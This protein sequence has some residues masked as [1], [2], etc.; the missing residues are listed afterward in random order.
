MIEIRYGDY[1]EV[2]DMAG[3]SVSEA[4]KQ[5]KAEFGIPDKTGAKL[6]GNKVKGGLES[7]IR[8]NDDDKLS[9]TEARGK[10]VF[11]LAAL[12]LSLAVTGGVF[13]YGLVTA[14]VTFSGVSVPAGAG[15][16][17]DVTVNNTVSIGWTPHG[18]SKGST[19]NGTLWD[20]DTASSGYTGD[21]VATVYITNA[22]KLIEV[23][24]VLAMFITVYDSSDNVVDI[25]GDGS[26]NVSTD[27][28]L[29]TLDN[30]SVDLNIAGAADVFTVKLDS[31][32]Y[33]TQIYGTGWTS[34]SEAPKLYIDVAQR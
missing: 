3:Q 27:Y 18:D 34:G 32:F 1:Y 10:G 29:L 31:G 28:A 2:A 11:L 23:Y 5:F 22:D 13:A 15:E 21:M 14:S 8:L 24:R 17:V 16:F 7:K 30:G 20:I 6:N 9:F 19:G 25:N 26:A 33:S 4:R 12:F